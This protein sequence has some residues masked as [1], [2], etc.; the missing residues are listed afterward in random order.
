MNSPKREPEYVPEEIPHVSE[1][2]QTEKT[3]NGNSTAIMILWQVAFKGAIE[4]VKKGATTKEFI[5]NLTQEYY[6]ILKKGPGKEVDEVEI[7]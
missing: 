7:E 3:S 5:A 2:P 4:M 1:Y 6:D